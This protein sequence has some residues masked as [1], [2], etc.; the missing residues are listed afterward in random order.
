M[1]GTAFSV[2]PLNSFGHLFQPLL[3]GRFS[4]RSEEEGVAME[5]MAEAKLCSRI[6]S[7]VGTRRGG[8]VEGDERTDIASS[9][10]PWR[11]TDF[12]TLTT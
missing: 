12:V 7:P 8:G 9:A 1:V 4:L 5:Q 10:F 6:I 11:V 3:L 2:V